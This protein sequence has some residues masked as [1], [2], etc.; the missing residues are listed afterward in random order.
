MYKLL[1]R[2]LLV[3]NNQVIE[4]YLDKRLS[5]NENLKIIKDL[6]ELDKDEFY[7]YDPIRKIFLDRNISLSSF[8]IETFRMFY[9]F[10]S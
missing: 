7:I 5:F 4:V 2:F 10:A 3:H 1:V 9:L 6:I 8:K